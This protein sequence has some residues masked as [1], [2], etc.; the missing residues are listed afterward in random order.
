MRINQLLNEETPPPAPPT[1]PERKGPGRGNWGP[2]R[3]VHSNHPGAGSGSRPAKTK[4]DATAVSEAPSLSLGAAGGAAAAGSTGPHG[5]YLPLNG[6]DPSHKRSRPLTAHQQAVEKYRKERVDFILDRRLR[7]EFRAKKRRRVR[8]GAVGRAWK[9]CKV[10]PDGYDTEEDNALGMAPEGVVNPPQQILA[11]GGL[12]PASLEWDDWGEEAHAWLQ[13]MRRAA[14]R[15]DRWEGGT[16]ESRKRRQVLGRELR[17]QD[18]EEQEE[19]ERREREKEE[20]EG[21]GDGDMDRERESSLPAGDGED[22]QR[23]EELD[24]MDRELLG[25]VDADETDDED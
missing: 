12:V 11:F 10:L 16:G 9:R 6:A 3:G 22:E 13:V 4:G 23:E 5:F 20:L 21:D 15:L 7:E 19:E 2:R 25:E 14:R 8:E 24:E 18:A 1:A 17:Y